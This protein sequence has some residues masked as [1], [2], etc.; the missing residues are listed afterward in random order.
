MIARY[1][2]KGQLIGIDGR[3]EV[4]QYDGKDGTKKTAYE[5]QVDGFS[6]CGSSGDGA[7]RQTQ[8]TQADAPEPPRD[9]QTGFEEVRDDELP[10]D[11]RG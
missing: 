9:E 2:K 7:Q 5:I 4:R 11:Y 8:N 3:L 1:F 10:F 6:F